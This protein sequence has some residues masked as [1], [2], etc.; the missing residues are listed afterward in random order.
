MSDL[1]DDLLNYDIG[2]VID[3]QVLIGADEDELLLSDEDLE[4][5][6][7]KEEK[8]KIK[9]EAEEWVKSQIKDKNK[10]TNV[11]AVVDTNDATGSNSKGSSKE[12]ESVAIKIQVGP[13]PH[14][15]DTT[16]IQG[17]EIKE[18]I[19][20]QSSEDVP[21]TTTQNDALLS[22]EVSS[23]SNK[24]LDIEQSST[25]SNSTGSGGMVNDSC[26]S[27]AIPSSQESASV[28]MSHG[29]IS[30]P[31]EDFEEEREERTNI[32][33]TNE[34]ETF[35]QTHE[36]SPE[37]SQ[38]RFVLHQKRNGAPLIRG[39]PIRGPS[40]LFPR[41]PLRF[42][43][44]GNIS[45]LSPAHFS[46]LSNL[47][48]VTLTHATA[49]PLITGQTFLPPQQ[50]NPN[51]FGPPTP[52]NTM[53]NP[54]H[55]PLAPNI[56][57]N[58]P[59]QRPRHP[60]GFRP[61]PM[62][63]FRHPNPGGLYAQGPNDFN[64]NQGP[65]PFNHPYGAP[66]NM[67]R[68]EGPMGNVPPGMRPG[69]RMQRP[70]LQALPP[71]AMPGQVN[72][73]NSPLQIRPQTVPGPQPPPV[74]NQSAAVAN[75]Q[76]SINQISVQP[77]PASAIAPRKVLI[78][79]NFK[80]GVE[81]A[82]SKFIQETQYMG[83]NAGGQAPR[84]QSDEELLRQQEEF[85]NKNREHI[86]KRRH[87]REVSPTRRS[88][89]RSPR[90]RSRTRSR[91]ISRER[92][93][94]PPKRQTNGG[95]NNNRNDRFDRER[96]RDRERE[97]ERERERPGNNDGNI[98]LG[99]A[100]SRDRD[101]RERDRNRPGPAYNRQAGGGNR[102]R[103]GNSRDRDY[104]GSGG[105]NYGKRRRSKSPSP[106]NRGGNFGNNRGRYNNDRDKPEVDEDEETRAYRLQIEKQKALREQ[107]MR[108]KEMKRR[109]AAEEKQYEE[110]RV[111]A[112]HPP[113]DD[114]SQKQSQTQMQQQQQPPQKFK[115]VVPERKII[116]LKK[117]PQTQTDSFDEH[118]NTQ[119]KS[120]PT[121]KILPEAKKTLTDHL[122]NNTPSGSVRDHSSSHAN[123]AVIK[124]VFIKETSSS[125]SQATVAA[126]RPQPQNHHQPPRRLSSRCEDE[127]QLDY[128][129]D[130]LL[131][132]EDDLLASEPET[133]PPRDTL[134]K[135]RDISH[136]PSP[137]PV[138]KALSRR[139][140]QARGGNGSGGGVSKQSLSSSNRRIVL[141]TSS[142]ST[143]SSIGNRAGANIS[144]NGNGNSRRVILDRL[145][146]RN[147][148]SS[149][150]RQQ[151]PAHGGVGGSSTDSKRK[152]Q[153]IILKHD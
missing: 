132:D 51:P 45:L 39:H 58:N 35:E 144:G 43:H 28:T 22:T 27:S 52:S 98:R 93:Y 124:P 8:Q 19:T 38:N 69:M 145:D 34:R 140:V 126:I 136:T 30:D 92:S 59:H 91:S 135:K 1:N 10:K 74:S 88:R 37:K 110:K 146:V 129:E 120:I 100:G 15:G 47:A 123:T 24:D 86:E 49:N 107:I 48:T 137:E 116:S 46:P 20:T 112:S 105:G 12:Q 111:S 65:A 25:V 18:E 90:S 78:N 80:G 61:G 134:A 131:L 143:S 66:R 94:S 70:P 64:P 97:R 128:D 125:A 138:G 122:T 108:D 5:D 23:S 36:Q 54:T 127:V 56:D 53:H 71:H 13:N 139:N 7:S 76:Q 21:S 6:V 101:D 33:T 151:S 150:S 17:N 11:P 44:H 99:R 148:N 106:G 85:I 75:N 41:P 149:G 118:A 142:N 87:A 55:G 14:E 62:G 133:S 50:T 42:P 115:E 96:D 63:G 102:F 117:R 104:Q 72:F 81:A 4:K 60:F 141:K 73:M 82:T 9:S 77:A 103:R 68:P 109:R 84:V 130:D 16:L 119:R 29:D 121:A 83:I 67:F 95:P 153:R 147:H 57:H 113:K 31:R 40:P 3:D 114:Q 152:P 32:K 89:S 79:P 26:A 2:D